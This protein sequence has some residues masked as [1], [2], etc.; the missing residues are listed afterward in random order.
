MIQ[1]LHSHTN[2][3]YCGSDSPESVVEAALRGGV[4][5]LGICDHN[6]GVA[7]QT[8]D[9]VYP[10]ESEKIYECQRYLDDYL[11][12]MRRVAEGYSDR[13]RVLCGLE[14]A[15]V[16]EEWRLLPDGVDVSKFDYCMIEHIDTDITV[17]D[18]IF[19]FAARCAT[20]RVGIAHTDIFSFLSRTGRDADTFFRRMAEEGIFWELNVN[21]DSIHGYREHE[22]VADFLSDERK[23][24][25]VL[26]SGA[27]LSVGF[28][29]H[30]VGDY[31]PDRVRACC[32][33]LEKGGFRLVFGG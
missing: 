13:I 30:R 18:D 14:I 17:V 11:S 31:R 9:S 1:D 20:G 22:Y 26:K 2:Y 15:T 33:K 28:D 7:R 25:I 32:E 24:E 27:E 8:P 6:Y 5:M 16:N 10:C 29:G 4:E 19:A 23:R 12:H 3:S 21:Y